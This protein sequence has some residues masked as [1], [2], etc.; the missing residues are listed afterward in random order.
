[1]YLICD[2]AIGDAYEAFVTG[3]VERVSPWAPII[4]PYYTAISIG[5][6]V[7][8]LQSCVQAI[9]HLIGIIHPTTLA[10]IASDP[11]GA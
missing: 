9:R 11:D 2:A 8:F 1:M 7:L 3:Q 4:W 5:L 6:S 10:L